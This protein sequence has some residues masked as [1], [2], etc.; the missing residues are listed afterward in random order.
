M[1][2]KVRIPATSIKG[3]FSVKL[4]DRDADAPSDVGEASPTQRP[5]SCIG[6]AVENGTKFYNLEEMPTLLYD[7][8]PHDTLESIR[9]E[10][11]DNPMHEVLRIFLVYFYG[12]LHCI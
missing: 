5:V 1:L 8:I 3:K 11:R 2:W 10:I 7:L 6:A 9:K 4:Y 12:T